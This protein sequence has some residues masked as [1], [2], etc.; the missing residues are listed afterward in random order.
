MPK[1][2]VQFQLHM[3]ENY[4]DVSRSDIDAAIGNSIA[5]IDKEVIMVVNTAAGAAPTVGVAI[6]TVEYLQSVNS[7]RN[8]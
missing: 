5:G 8:N 3:A 2:S 7:V 1:I 6:I 4:A